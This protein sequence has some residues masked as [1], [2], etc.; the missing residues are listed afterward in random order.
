MDELVPSRQ[1]RQTELPACVRL[2]LNH[3][4]F[5]WCTVSDVCVMVWIY[6]QICNR[7]F[8]LFIYLFL[9]LSAFTAEQYQQHQEQLALMQKQQ[10][11]QIQLQQQANSTATANSTQVSALLEELVCSVSL[12][13]FSPLTN[14]LLSP[15][16]L[17]GSGE[18]VG[19]GQRSVRRLSP[20][21]RRPTAGSKNQGGASPGRRSQWRPL[22][23]RY[24]HGRQ[25]VDSS[26][27]KVVWLSLLLLLI[28]KTKGNHSF[29]LFI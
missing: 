17:T 25:S 3:V 18:H 12:L 19:P 6:F 16:S 1:Q 26:F 11:E 24:D 22:P 13:F 23:L 29:L 27:Y 14:P 15:F 20:R 7:T 4:M 9:S 5:R 10:L 8:Y 28:I 2:L 21:H